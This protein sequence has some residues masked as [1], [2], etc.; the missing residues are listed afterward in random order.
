M[1]MKLWTEGGSDLTFRTEESRS[2]QIL[3]GRPVLATAYVPPQSQLESTVL[4]IWQQ[5][6][7]IERLGVHDNFFDLGRHSLFGLRMITAVKKA[8]QIDLP[9]M[10]LFE[11][12]TVSALC[13]RIEEKQFVMSNLQESQDR[14]KRRRNTVIEENDLKPDYQTSS[15]V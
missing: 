3:P 7:G 13:Q 10:A 2:T 1:R 4:T 6:L 9:I 14:G 12:P 8:L 5:I 11:G 15:P